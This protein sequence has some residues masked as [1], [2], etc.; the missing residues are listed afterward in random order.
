MKLLQLISI[1]ASCMLLFSCEKNVLDKNPL[2]EIDEGLVW[3]DVKL[4]TLYVNKIYAEIPGGINR[5]MDCATDLGDEGH[6]WGSTQTWNIGDITQD[7][8]PFQDGWYTCYTQI[9]AV[10]NL[11]V[12][13]GTLKGSAEAIDQL[14]GQAYFLRAY[15][16]T[17]LV[18]L[19]G[20]VPLIDKPQALTD[21]LLVARN[22][23]DECV[24][25][26]SADLDKAVTLLPEQWDGADVGRASKGA[27]LALKSRILL[28]AAS[29]LHNQGN[30]SAK[31]QAASAAAKAVI[32]LN[33]YSLYSDYYKL[34]HVDNNSEVI[35][36]LQYAFPIR[37]QGAEYR[38][39]PQGFQ[40]AFGAQRPSQ[41]LVDRYEMS[42]GKAIE[43]A[44]SGY[45]PDNPYKDRDPRFY[46]SILY[47]GAPWRSRILETFADGANGPGQFD[48]YST[49]GQMTGYYG[50]KFITE[51]NPIIYGVD[52]SNNNWILIRYAEILLNYAEA[53][54]ALGNFVEGRKY[55][56]MVRTR[57][58]LPDLT[59]S[60][61][62]TDL[63]DK[64]R[65][66]RTVELSFEEIYFFDVRRWQLAEVLVGE[67]LNK[68]DITKT[69][70]NQYTY[71]VNEMEDREW[72][73]AFYYL[74]IPLD[75]INKNPNL[76][77]N[78]GYQ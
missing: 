29:P 1:L 7:Y 55:I 67:P 58:G 31:W 64:L 54:I 78:P 36:D 22:S 32:D 5:N 72:R 27:A 18:N 15:F 60:L 16:Y 24:G 14:K 48:Q 75:E 68:M 71:E 69:G 9:R 76:Q 45:D 51:T 30:S 37:T 13:A 57:A 17:Q 39:N 6:N 28:S 56:N 40:G 10:N 63:M 34:F 25:F 70:T 33:V 62:G 49:G 66:E 65:N 21:S 41:Q 3:T 38:N 12:N 20:G 42:N 8:A 23:Y 73:P 2:G 43:E 26:I 53:Q 11:L 46:Q 74:P 50:R 61:A 35:F 4:A 59:T 47:N 19:F 44:G 77:Q 52:R